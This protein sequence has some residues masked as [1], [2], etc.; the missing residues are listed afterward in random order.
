MEFT[1]N[2]AL[3]PVAF[4]L[5]TWR[6]EGK[7]SYPTADSFAYNEEIVFRHIGRPFLVY[8]QRT[9]HPVKGSP[10]HGEMGYWRPQAGGRIELVIVHP[11]GIAEIEEGTIDGTTIEVATTVVGKTTTAKEV[12]R[13]ERTFTVEGDVMRYE[14]RMAAVG[15]PLTSHL[16]AELKRAG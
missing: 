1:L 9:T 2:P 16:T 11:T 14:V 5:G 10:M 4:L 15:V 13:L 6:G 7:G 3:E 12:T 8:E